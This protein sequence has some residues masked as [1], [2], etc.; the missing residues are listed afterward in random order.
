MWPQSNPSQPHRAG[1]GALPSHWRFLAGLSI[2]GPLYVAQGTKVRESH[3][4]QQVS[5]MEGR[6]VLGQAESETPIPQFGLTRK[7]DSW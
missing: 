6:P 7:R 1:T 5:Q 2:P 3:T 4:S